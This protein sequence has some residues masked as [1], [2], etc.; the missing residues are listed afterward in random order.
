MRIS[1]LVKIVMS[2]KFE[3]MTFS[4]FEYGD[5]KS[6]TEAVVKLTEDWILKGKAEINNAE[7]CLVDYY[8]PR[9]GGHLPEKFTCWQSAYYPDKIFFM[10]N[11]SDGWHTMCMAIQR[12]L[13]FS[14]AMF[15]MSGISSSHSCPMNMFLYSKEPGTERAVL[16]Y[17]DDTHWVFYDRGEPVEFENV[18]NYKARLKKNRLNKDILMEY[19]RRMGINFYDI[20]EN[21]IHYLNF[22]RTKW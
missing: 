10:S 4:V 11:L 19:M 6:F 17:Y 2:D 8:N 5:F 9:I 15:E 13:N 20:D 21:I 7:V 16:S 12:Q 18:E 14:W 22:I 1:D 3:F